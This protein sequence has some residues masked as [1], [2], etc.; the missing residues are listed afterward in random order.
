MNKLFSFFLFELIFFLICC[1]SEK[2]EEQD[3]QDQPEEFELYG[4]KEY[5]LSP[6]DTII[7]LKINVT[8]I[9]KD[10]YA[11][12]SLIQNDP[13]HINFTYKFLKEEEE[14]D[15]KNYK[16]IINN[17]I[18]NNYSKHTIYYRVRKESASHTKL[19]LKIFASTIIAGQKLTIKQTQ[20][21][22]NLNFVVKVLLT[23]CLIA[24][25]LA[26]ASAIVVV[27][28]KKREKKKKEEEDLED[29]NEVYFPSNFIIP[30]NAEKEVV[31]IDL[32]GTDDPKS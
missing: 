15:G 29:P 18:I 11:F 19:L 27:I 5:I 21:Q 3:Q 10:D 22:T 12:F 16:K 32:P 8:K 30:V 31:N 4:F 14:D 28:K 17:G 24:F 23:I 1:K 26:V 2:E 13:T 7:Y 6:G 20:T 25:L 9:T